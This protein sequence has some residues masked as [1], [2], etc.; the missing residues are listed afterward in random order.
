M[1]KRHSWKVLAAVSVGGGMALALPVLPAVGQISPPST[2]AVEV[3]DQA[4]LVA[5][6]AAVLVP[7]EVVCPAGSFAYLST[8]VNQRAGSRIATG[9]ASTSD[10]ACTG[11]TQI[12]NVL[13]Y[14]QGQ[15]F[16][17]GT[18]VAD[19]YLSVYNGYFGQTV[20]DNEI[21]QIAR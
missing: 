18:A 17:Q 7:V 9:A 10:F 1:T 4:T 11:A 19:A 8:T 13:V 14:A 5:R 21:I 20:T 6:G 2:V 16:K 3:T 12:V 15:A